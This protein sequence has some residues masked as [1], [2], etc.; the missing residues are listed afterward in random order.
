VWVQ[1]K[2][3]SDE[4]HDEIKAKFALCFNKTAPTGN[5][6]RKLKEV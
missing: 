6:L 1:E 2:R 3:R 4:K 5:K